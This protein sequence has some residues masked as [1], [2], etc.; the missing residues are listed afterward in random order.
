MASLDNSETAQGEG[1]KSLRTSLEKQMD[2]KTEPLDDERSSGAAD[3]EPAPQSFRRASNAEAESESAAEAKEVETQ[4]NIITLWARAMQVG[5]SL[6][7]VMVEWP[8]LLH[9]GLAIGLAWL[10]GSF[11]FNMPFS[12]V[13][14]LVYLASV[15][16][17]QR[18]ALVRRIR[19][20]ERQAAQQKRAMVDS[21]SAVWLNALLERM[22]P[23]CV[24]RLMAQVV[25]PTLAPWF[26]DKYKPWQLKKAVLQKLSLGSKP[27]FVYS[28]R[29][30][31][32]VDA[33]AND[34]VVEM[35]FEFLADKEMVA[36][37]AGQTRYRTGF[38]LW[39]NC[40]VSRLQVEGKLK[41]GVTFVADFPY[42]SHVRISFASAPYIADK[43]LTTALELSLVEPNMLVL[44]VAKLLKRFTIGQPGSAMEAPAAG[45]AEEFFS[46]EE[47][48]KPFQA[49]AVIEVLEAEQLK[50]A[51]AN[52]LSD[53]YVKG[54]LGS[55]R[56]RTAVKRKTLSPKWG[57]E[58][59]LHVT[60]WERPNSLLVLTVM[61]KDMFKSDY[62]GYVVIDLATCR[63]GQRIERWE[64]LQDVSTGCLRVAIVIKEAPL[65][66]RS[67]PAAFAPTS[68]SQDV[69]PSAALVEE[70]AP[71]VVVPPRA[72]AAEMAA[73]Q[74]RA[75]PLRVPDALGG[76]TGG[77]AGGARGR[78][79]A[80][81]TSSSQQPRPTRAPT[82]SPPPV[83]Q[84]RSNSPSPCTG[85]SSP[86][87]LQPL[88]PNVS[89][90]SSPASDGQRLPHLGS[91]LLKVGQA[92]GDQF[93]FSSA[94]P[95]D[96]SYDTS[97]HATPAASPRKLVSVPSSVPE[98]EQQIVDDKVVASPQ[99]WDSDQYPGSAPTGHIWPSPVPPF[100]S[101]GD[102]PHGN[103][104]RRSVADEVDE[105]PVG[106]TDD[107]AVAIV[108]PGSRS[109][110][111]LWTGRLGGR[112][113]EAAC[114]TSWLRADA[115]EQ[116]QLAAPGV[117]GQ[118]LLMAGTDGRSGRSEG[119]SGHSREFLQPSGDGMLVGDESGYYGGGDDGILGGAVERDHIN[120]SQENKKNRTLKRLKHKVTNLLN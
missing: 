19:S 28:A 107:G 12:L 102:D 38:G 21:E 80:L 120:G 17:R 86:D 78:V 46:V 56:F 4:G 7:D 88:V 15:E 45:P 50:A 65:G 93:E 73:Q 71:S 100:T 29:V 55:Q 10:A 116:G 36:V 41:V 52:G 18:A 103:G 20:Q 13:L 98:L 54:A 104:S 30:V 47:K 9:A 69:E 63:G 118:G 94:P 108:R 26:F 60:S 106:M 31:P 44:D 79:G 53:P 114:R 82:R 57:E 43:M 112:R 37:L 59:A 68:A 92:A 105:I 40:H 51:D 25:L 66:P 6:T 8:L 115:D 84:R 96:T 2:G 81:P 72:F 11:N 74:V 35:G 61:D 83:P 119:V 27:P 111:S 85:A 89:P 90:G 24:E 42:I 16:R 62:L 117:D 48:E 70:E 14:A 23:V 91:P 77:D 22:W 113:K 3:K 64:K 33:S 87:S 49:E 39:G 99:V 95:S 76:G 109:E 1:L 97:P 5:E 75:E 32:A 34:A 110:A 58:F 101:V 67:P